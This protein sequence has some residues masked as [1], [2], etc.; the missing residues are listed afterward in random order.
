MQ[1]TNLFSCRMHVEGQ[2][3]PPPQ[4]N[5]SNS[6]S[7]APHPYR[8]SWP[9]G[10]RLFP[11]SR[12][13]RTSVYP[14]LGR[15]LLNDLLRQE[16]ERRKNIPFYPIFLLTPHRAVT[17]ATRYLLLGQLSPPVKLSKA[18]FHSERDCCSLAT[19]PLGDWVLQFSMKC[20]IQG[21]P[22]LKPKIHF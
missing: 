18:L 4:W 9:Q 10:Q 20:L 8:N 22:L 17:I 19:L 15:W 6:V 3:H 2:C 12:L 14:V 1:S 11:L 13:S 5:I 7:A 16:P 21:F